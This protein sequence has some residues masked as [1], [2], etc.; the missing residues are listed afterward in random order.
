MTHE[1]QPASGENRPEPEGLQTSSAEQLGSV[2][3]ERQ[4]SPR[5]WVGSLAD[6]NNGDLH[7]EWLDAARE[8]EDIHEDIQA[9]LARGP[10]ARRG[11]APEEWG[12]F[13]YD[14]FGSLQ[15]GEYERIEDVS[16]LA[17]AV[18]KHGPAFAAWAEATSRDQATSED[19]VEAF[20]GRFDSPAAYAEELVADL[21][22]DSVLETLPGWLQPYVHIDYD[23]LAHD[24]ELGGDIFTARAGDGG[25][26]VFREL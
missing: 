4:L 11:E 8:P 1:Q 14:E 17:K 26:Y 15:I 24:L 7:G 12:I 21:E 2:E 10:A 19:F 20:H 16:R 9:M 23:A 25:V 22:G 13:D 5:I 3:A 6:Y 18:A